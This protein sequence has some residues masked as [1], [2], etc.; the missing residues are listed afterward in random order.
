MKIIPGTYAAIDGKHL[1]A[2]LFW[3]LF[4]GLLTIPS[5]LYAQK[6]EITFEHLSLEEGLSDSIVTCILQD[7]KGFLWVGTENGLNKYD[8]YEFIRYRHDPQNPQS[9]SANEV[10]VIY[11]DQLGELWLGTEDGL[12]T[13]NR[14]KDQFVHYPSDPDNPN[15]LLNNEILSIYE[16]HA[17]VL[18]IGTDEGLHAYDRAQN[19]FIRYQSDSDSIRTIY[20]DRL[21]MLW[22]G[23]DEGLNAYDGQTF[24]AYSHDPADPNSLGH[25]QVNVIYEDRLGNLWIGADD[26][27]LHRF[28]RETE[29]F[30]HYRNIPGDDS[31][32]SHDQ[33]STMYEDR[34]GILWIGTLNGLNK[35]V[36]SPSTPLRIDSVKG[37]DEGGDRRSERFIRYQHDPANPRSLS[38]N[39]IGAIFE[40]RAGVLW[41]GTDGGGLNKF[42]RRT[43]H[44]LHYQHR[45]DNPH[46]L[47]HNRVQ[48][49]YE[50]R[51]GVLWIGTEVGG[52]NRLDRDTE[53]FSHYRHNPDDPH[54]LS[55]NEV[56]ALYEDHTGTLWVGTDEGGLDRLIRETGQFIHYAPEPDTPGSLSHEKIIFLYEDQ[57]GMLWIGTEGGGLNQLDRETESFTTYQHAEDDPNSLSDD[58]VWAIYEDREGVLWIGTNDGL[59]RFD[60]E[61]EKFLRYEADPDNP[62]SLNHNTIWSIYEDQTGVLWIGT[63]GGLNRYDRT[64][65]TF[66]YYTEHDGLPH[67]VIYGI[68]KDE[69]GHLWLST[70]KGL[71]QFDPLTEIFK[72]YGVNELQNITFY[73]GA[74]HKSRSG[75]M[76][77]GGMHGFNAF[78]PQHIT[79]N[80]HPPQ[81]VFTDFRIF[82]R[83]VPVSKRTDERSILT[84]SI[85]ETQ[86]LV[87]SYKDTVFSFEFAALDYTIPEKNQ[88]AY[89]MEGFDQEWNE[90]GVRRVATYTNFP[91]GTYV[92]RVR[93][94]NNDGI[95]SEQEARLMITVTPPWWETWWFR[96]GI[97]VLVMGSVFG[98][99]YLRIRA[100]TRQKQRLEARVAER[101]NELARAKDAA[102][103]ANRAKSKFLSN[104]SHELRTPLNGILG[105]AQ[106][107][108]RDPDL[109]RNGPA[110]EGINII[111]Q[112]GEHLL[113][114]INDILDLSKIEAQKLELYPADFHLP[115]F[116]EGIVGI[117]RMQA[118]QKDLRLLDEVSPSLPP[119]IHA[120]EKRLRQVLLNLLGNAM[121]FTDTGS[122]VTFRVECESSAF[123]SQRGAL[124]LRF[125]VEDTGIGMTPE[126]QQKIF[127]PFEQVGDTQR[128]ASG[129]GLGLAISRQLVETMGGKL[130]VASEPGKGSTFWFEL[131]ILVA[132]VDSISTQPV[133]RRE[134]TGYTG[135]RRRLLVVDDRLHNRGVLLS[136]LD[137]LR[138]EIIE[139]E[140]G[141][142]ALEKAQV[143]RPDLILMDIMMPVMTGI[144][145]T[146]QLRQ[147]PET[148]DMPI[149]AV[150][151]SVFGADIEQALVAGCNDF[152]AKP[153]E[154]Q[155]VFAILEKYLHLEW[156]YREVTE[157][158]VAAP[159]AIAIKEQELVLPSHAVLEQ[160]HQLA[161]DG[162]MDEVQE[163]AAQLEQQA[164]RYRP[165]ARKVHTLATEFQDEQL[166]AVVK[167]ALEHQQKRSRS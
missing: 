64:S 167:K 89:K 73:E 108:K 139:A 113:T 123:A 136:L 6:N 5:S 114:L 155:K 146:Q 143:F 45:P 20:Q 16:D 18:W 138:F 81:V 158:H 110:T 94:T 97:A 130:Q 29:Q 96:G 33:V 102:E 31:S 47:S 17:S 152:L 28:D 82:N 78:Y 60:R 13:Y 103:T 62:K 42:N 68:L 122:M 21:G 63:S 115:S 164:P 90:I 43:E 34:A 46:S 49:L 84:Q 129:T 141:Q 11:E 40:D 99:F 15:S 106:I 57:T 77:F 7:R 88:Y 32:L 132:A 154:E 135:K 105:Y 19:R 128:R 54:S 36:L 147:M 51:S 1:K 55:S 100:L 10:T 39:E 23:T 153:V 91:A 157:E 61:T 166:V 160:L 109:M 14:E 75:E 76:F 66:K 2:L 48:A 134:I 92:F 24:T 142:Q 124:T 53:E 41:I 162:D 117:I 118:Q 156:M 25:R 98:A 79:D 120:D 71:S 107:L 104:M 121:K 116:L 95:W 74:Y 151:A 35:L 127:R 50:D 163:W 3:G 4:M 149:I 93:G 140:N 85:T 119:G 30:M 22:F 38:Y 65:G 27:G 83:S 67:D 145:A 133:T 52:L 26:G 87:L 150:S 86:E 165:F 37:E 69:Q 137:P 125:E 148:R 101:T 59:N 161:L 58:E 72:N 44:F 8:G 131:E 159:E 111:Q 112:S 12:Q 126:E 144:E 80:P 70:G 9:L 56:T